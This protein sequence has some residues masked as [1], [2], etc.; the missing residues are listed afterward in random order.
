M[1]PALAILVFVVAL[2]NQASGVVETSA[3]TNSFLVSTDSELPVLRTISLST[4]TSPEIYYH[5]NGQIDSYVVQPGGGAAVIS[6]G[7]YSTAHNYLGGLGGGAS[8]SSKVTATN[9]NGS[10]L[11]MTGTSTAEVCY[12]QDY[13]LIQS[14]TFGFGIANPGEGE[15]DFGV[16][17]NQSTT[18][19][20]LPVPVP[21]VMNADEFLYKELN[22]TFKQKSLEMEEPADFLQQE[23]NF[24]YGTFNNQPTFYG[25]DFSSVLTV[26]DTSCS[27]YMS[28]SH[29]N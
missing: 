28:F 20:T 24:N 1:K 22:V 8:F 15:Y 6:Q 25:Y 23:I 17:G 18:S 16:N 3:Y 11:V 19:T 26:E 14:K 12:S 9:T 4:V 5:S 29:V 7:V 10:E 21:K 13:A 2:A 27:S